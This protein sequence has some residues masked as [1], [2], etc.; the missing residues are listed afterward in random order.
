MRNQ[1]F[2][3]DTLTL[4]APY[5][6]SSGAPVL[7]GNLFLIASV[8]ALAGQPFSGETEGAFTLA[9]D[10]AAV[11]ALGDPVYFD[12]DTHLCVGH[13]AGKHLI[14]AAIGPAG[15]GAASVAVRLNAVTTAVAA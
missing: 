3:G 14:G 1:I 12:P 4:P 6:L 10:P 13:V 8:D 2:S 15:N 7:I 11:F 9:K 5:N